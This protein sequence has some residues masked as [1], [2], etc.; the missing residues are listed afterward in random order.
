MQR[1]TQ[2]NSWYSFN[3][4]NQTPC[5]YYS[6]DFYKRKFKKRK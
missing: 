2:N 3:Y 4:K 6:S 1:E 5:G